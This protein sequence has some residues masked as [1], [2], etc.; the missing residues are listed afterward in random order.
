[1]ARTVRIGTRVGG[2]GAR[3]RAL[4]FAALAVV[5]ACAGGHGARDSAAPAANAA[6]TASGGGTDSAGSGW[7]ALFD[8]SGLS[9]WR[10]YKRQE[11]PAGWRVA[12]GALA[13]EPGG[14][15]SSRGDIMTRGQYSDFELA[16]EWRIA[17]GGNSGVM[18]RVD[19]GHQFPW[20]TGPEMQVL[21]N[22]RHPDGKNALTSA[23]AVYALYAPPSDVT[24][25]VGE[26]NSARIVARGAHVEHWLN[27]TKT[28][29]YERG[30]DDWRRRVKASKFATMPAFGTLARGHIVLQDHGD[31]VWYRNIRIRS[32][33]G[34]S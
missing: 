5:T 33:D 19:A 7:V 10:G 1:M 11:V 28:A 29:E 23:A 4:A 14:D 8:G 24:R 3:R 25:P 12:E 31:R 20:E 34:A 21:D 2:T 13:F 15:S 26:W 22:A 16:Y 6:G 30:S 9:Q 32:F 27:G 18:Y 17:P